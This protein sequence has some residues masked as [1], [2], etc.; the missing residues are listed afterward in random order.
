MATEELELRQQ[1]AGVQAEEMTYE[2]FEEEE[3]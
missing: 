2:K 3:N 1:I